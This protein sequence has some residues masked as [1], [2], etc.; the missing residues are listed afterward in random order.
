MHGC[1]KM[2]ASLPITEGALLLHIVFWTRL[3]FGRDQVI[4]QLGATP[5]VRLSVCATLAECIDALPD[6]DG[7]ILYN[8]QAPDAR[9]LAQ[10]VHTRAPKLT[11]MH[12]LTAGRDGFDGIPLP[13]QVQTTG[14]AGAFAPAVAEHAM[15]LMLA[16]ARKLPVALQQQADRRWDR[17]LA[18][19]MTSLEGRT[20]LI[21]GLGQIGR[22]I[23]RRARV[24][25]VTTIGV[26]RDGRA[27]DAVDDCLPLS[28]L[29]AGLARSDIVVLSIAL[30]PQTRHLLDREAFA[31]CQPGTVLIN[32]ARGGVVDQ[33]ALCDALASGHLAGAGLDVVE[34]EPL[35]ADDPL[36]QQPNLIVT[37]HLAVEGSLASGVRVAN[38]TLAELHRRWSLPSA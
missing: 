25:G 28:D 21:V 23:A 5:G 16:L 38:G 31:A 3:S 36:W 20:M 35:P 7:L 12:F 6:A 13:E 19:S 30:T 4:Q 1:M 33:A 37:P 26:T 9:T 22:E 29:H 32:V 15:A 8:C 2:P 24:F 14:V 34:P 10:A 27:D 18:S 11:W 17:S